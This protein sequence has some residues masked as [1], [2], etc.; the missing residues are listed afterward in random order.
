MTIPTRRVS[1]LLVLLPLGACAGSAGEPAEGP[2]AAPATPAVA[3]LGS[4]PIPPSRPI[5]SVV[6]PRPAVDIELTGD[7]EVSAEANSDDG[8]K[9]DDPPDFESTMVITPDATLSNK[10]STSSNG[11]F[12]DR[13]KKQLANSDAADDEDEA[14]IQTTRL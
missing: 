5:P 4:A 6:P 14:F 13:V 1:A 8:N 12:I 10:P 11:A 9:V 3:P 2:G 7:I